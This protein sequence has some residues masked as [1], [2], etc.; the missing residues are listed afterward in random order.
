MRAAL[1]FMKYIRIRSV[2]GEEET[3]ARFIR[4]ELI[5]LG[6]NTEVDSAGNVFGKRKGTGEP[7]LFSCH[8][9]TVPHDEPI[10]PVIVDGIIKS[11]GETILGADN[12]AG[13]AILLEAIRKSDEEKT[14]LRPLEIVLSISEEI[15]LVGMKA[16]NAETLSS[17]MGVVLDSG[18]KP[19]RIVVRGP[20]QDK[21][22]FWI[23][24]KKAHA[25][26]EPEKGISAINVAAK[27]I[28][29][30][31]LLRI[32]DET[33]A[34]I[35]VISGGTATNI[36]ADEVYIKAEARSL[37]VKKLEE[38][39]AHMVLTMEEQ[40]EKS[41]AHLVK[42]V[43]RMYPPFS[44]C[45][46]EAVISLVKKA[47]EKVNLESVLV[48]TGGGSDT[49]I[50][51]DRGIPSVNLSIGAMNAHT[52]DE[53]ISLEDIEISVKMVREIIKK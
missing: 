28:A 53:Y 1:E 8:M 49:S 27:A 2:S 12:K 10:E 16:F 52:K 25:G 48:S 45:E 11:A 39:S 41:G 50:L 9:D 7:V 31:K 26:V 34:N 22:E 35:G 43:S 13:I 23:K 32:D 40:C 47:H 6:F 46:D 36:V 20:S 30:M 24:G 37:D 17:K 51:N 33:T 44:V 29:S 18:G 15:G 14:E 5:N 42:K 21:L 4:D 3:F 19:G 38:Q